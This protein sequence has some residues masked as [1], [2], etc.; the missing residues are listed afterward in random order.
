MKAKKLVTNA[1]IAALYA[2]CT[3]ALAPISYGVMQFRV[4]EALTIL[5][6]INPMCTIGLT[7]GCL[8]SNLV[9]GYGLLDIVF[10]SLATMLAGLWTAKIKRSWLAPLPPVICNGIIV[11]ALLAWTNTSP[12]AFGAALLPIGTQLMAEEAA[13]CYLLGLPLLVL[14]KKSKLDRQLMR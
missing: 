13:V 3:L 4:S 8:V 9:G 2:G 10:G 1:L 7:I 6:F 5:P 14:L 12:A 11:G